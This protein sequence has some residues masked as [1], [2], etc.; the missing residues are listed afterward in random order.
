MRFALFYL[1]ITLWVLWRF[2][3]PMHVARR[4]KRAGLV[5]ILAIAS[6]SYV[7][8]AFFGGLISP[9]LPPWVL[10]LGHGAEFA[11]LFLAVLTLAREVVIF[12]CVLAGKSARPAKRTVQRD[13]RVALGMM[14]ASAGLAVAG[15]H[16]GIKVPDV[17][18]YDVP[19][20]DLP[21]GLEGMTVVQLSD[22]HASALL[23]EPHMQALVERVNALRPDLIL[24][25]GD[26]V[27]GTVENR[28]KDMAPLAKLKARHGVLACEGNHEHYLDYEGWC[29]RIPELGIDLMKNECRTIRHHGA[30][31][32][33]GAVTDPWA[34]R[35]DRE[36]PDVVKAFAGA[37]ETGPR[38][39]MAHQPKPARSYDEAVRI[40]LIL[41]G[42]THGGQLR[43]MDYAVA[44]MNATF[45]RGWYRLK[46]ALLY[47]HSGS[48]LW[49]GFPVRLGVPSEI[50]LFTLV[51]KSSRTTDE[52][53][54][55]QD[56]RKA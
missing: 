17:L 42:H 47:V 56:A 52:L 12:L 45:V 37:P 33:V 50:A 40:D 3:K 8:A 16:E 10:A 28:R 2:L 53:P 11:L 34:K 39:L 1:A 27:D 6:F 24:I 13:R 26:L 46:H 35:F 30:L 38:I 48:G 32:T 41:S 20:E 54:V 43:G 21:D 31:L 19:I 7:S 18:R 36:L 44:V 5:V 25:T 9:E 29:R 14:A 55:A 15:V 51:K 23:T 4:Y 49:N 22:L